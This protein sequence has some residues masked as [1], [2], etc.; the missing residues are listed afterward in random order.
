MISQNRTIGIGLSVFGCLFMF[1]GVLMMFDRPLLTMGNLLFLGG[2]TF[3]LGIKR[4]KTFFFQ[5]SK[6]KITSLF[7]LGIFFVMIGWT[8][9][10][11]IIETIGFV[12]L[13]G[14]FLP[15]VLNFL[16]F[17]PGIGTI[18]NHSVVKKISNFI[19]K[20]QELPL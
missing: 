20:K 14:G 8:I 7:F 3:L 1:I 19:G 11:L 13:F 15:S 12:G 17:V 6:I 9:I 10:G 18:T 2:I 16:R 5:K 4:T